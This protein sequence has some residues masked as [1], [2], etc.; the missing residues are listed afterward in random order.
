MILGEKIT[1]YFICGGIFFKINQFHRRKHRGALVPRA[2]C[3]EQGVQN[4][5]VRFGRRRG[6]SG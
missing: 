1:F 2:R 6:R 3:S 5:G 4:R